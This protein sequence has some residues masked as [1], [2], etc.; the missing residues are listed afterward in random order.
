LQ[1]GFFRA[2]HTLIE[3]TVVSE[4]P[5]KRDFASPTFYVIF[6]VMPHICNSQS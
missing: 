4:T 6:Y 2:V 3:Q 5:L 1:F